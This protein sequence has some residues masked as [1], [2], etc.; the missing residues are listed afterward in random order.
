MKFIENEEAF[1]QKIGKC[2]NSNE[3]LEESEIK[4]V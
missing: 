3:E 4:R 1:L 2:R